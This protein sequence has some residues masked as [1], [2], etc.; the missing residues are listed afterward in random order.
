MKLIRVISGVYQGLSVFGNA[1]QT[2]SDENGA[3][4]EVGV[5]LATPGD[6][7]CPVQYDLQW[8][9]HFS[10]ECYCLVSYSITLYLC[11]TT[12]KYVYRGQID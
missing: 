11:G 10:H 2:A 5:L 1:L 6:I 7:L 3:T 12:S 4:A 8:D 9:V